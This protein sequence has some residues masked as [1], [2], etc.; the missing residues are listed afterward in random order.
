MKNLSLMGTLLVLLTSCL[1]TKEA[2]TLDS[3]HL[4]T[5]TKPTANATLALPQKTKLSSQLPQLINH[6]RPPIQ[7]DIKTLLNNA[8]CQP[9]TTQVING[10]DDL[11]T[12][13]GCDQ[14]EL[15]NPLWGAI[16]PVYPL[17]ACL[18]FQTPQRL[19]TIEQEG[20]ITQHQDKLNYYRRYLIW[21]DNK[22]QLIKQINE[23]QSMFAPIESATEALSYAL[24]ATPFQAQYQ[25]TLNPNYRYYVS[26]IE[27][28]HV[29]STAKDYQVLLYTK[30][31]IGCGSHP[32]STVLVTVNRNGLI[33]YP[34]QQLA[35]ADP[36][37]DNWCVNS[38]ATNHN[39]ISY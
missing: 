14:L 15:P 31:K 32:T 37:E 9:T 2:T 39:L 29:V 8:H 11:R 12:Q 33:S 10:C 17:I 25:Q 4:T 20:Y 22:F 13:M 3:N 7:M 5:M 34:S 36:V 6:S 24:M 16:T 38:S 30:R 19:E 23:L 35:Y 21:K 28:T 1:A 26:R 18:I 27:D